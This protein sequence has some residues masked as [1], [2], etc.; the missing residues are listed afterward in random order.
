MVRPSRN[1]SAHPQMQPRRQPAVTGL[2]RDN[3]RR[4]DRSF[5]HLKHAAKARSSFADGDLLR[6]SRGSGACDGLCPL[7]GISRLPPGIAKR[8]PL[9]GSERLGTPRCHPPKCPPS[10]GDSSREGTS[11]APLCL[12]IGRTW[13]VAAPA[14]PTS[15]GPT[16][17][18]SC[19]HRGMSR[20]ALVL[21]HQHGATTVPTG[22]TAKACGHCRWSRPPMLSCPAGPKDRRTPTAS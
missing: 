11:G 4:R 1:G 14:R 20:A 13:L 17:S 5:P 10:T 18:A 19:D 16:L 12:R 22:G 21:A 8:R 3:S 15:A 9:D 2:Q 6:R 7:V